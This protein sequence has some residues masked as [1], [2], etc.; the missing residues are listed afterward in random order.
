VEGQKKLLAR[1]AIVH[2]WWGD[3]YIAM[4]D[5]PEEISSTPLIKG[6]LTE[7]GDT[8]VGGYKISCGNFSADPAAAA[9]ARSGHMPDKFP[10]TIPI[11]VTSPSGV[12]K[13]IDT[14]YIQYPNNPIGNTSPEFKLPASSDNIP[15]A[16]A[17][18]SLNA[19]SG[20]A[21]IYIRDSNFPP[22]R[23]YT[24]EVSTRPMVGLVWLGTILIALGGLVSMR[25]RSLENLVPGFETVDRDIPAPELKSGKSKRKLSDK[26]A[27]AFSSQ[28]KGS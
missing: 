21:D 3:I 27:T 11:T 19:D 13:E 5:G 1:P 26:P 2:R 9:M 12:V 8:T 10:V 15:W 18:S 6:T 28:G 24:I 25:R 4:K 22:V 23:E 16:I 17:V 20:Q 14:Q 7:G